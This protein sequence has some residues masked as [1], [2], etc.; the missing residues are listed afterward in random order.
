MA[1][2]EPQLPVEPGSGQPGEAHAVAGAGSGNAGGHRVD[3]AVGPSG[4]WAQQD[5][6]RPPPL[7]V[8][9]PDAGFSPPLRP[10]GRQ[11]IIAAP[12]TVIGS[13]SSTPRSPR[14]IEAGVEVEPPL[15]MEFGALRF[16]RQV[17][18]R[19]LADGV[20]GRNAA[21]WAQ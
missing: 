16:W 7:Q 18:F 1:T 2:A 3:A 11:R 6:P 5:V 4:D 15:Q 21:G 14:A 10:D 19:P 20:A 9:A 17:S 8:S 13:G 12:G